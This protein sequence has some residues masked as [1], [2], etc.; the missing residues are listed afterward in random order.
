MEVGLIRRCVQLPC[1]QCFHC[2]DAARAFHCR[3]I[4]LRPDGRPSVYAVDSGTGAVVWTEVIP[5]VTS[6]PAIAPNGVCELRVS[7]YGS[8]AVVH[9]CRATYELEA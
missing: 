1:F 6:G 3:R 7:S 4:T 2:C 9:Y 5:S 8:A